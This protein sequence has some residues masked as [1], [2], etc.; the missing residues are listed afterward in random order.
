MEK[1]DKHLE[2]VKEITNPH[3]YIHMYIHA[4]PQKSALLCFYAYENNK[5]A[6]K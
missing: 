2:H 6:Q 4:A 3:T 1:R 5:N